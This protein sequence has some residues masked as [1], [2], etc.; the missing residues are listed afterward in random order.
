MSFFS[1]FKEFAVKGNVVDLAVGVI[2]GAAFGKIVDSLVGDLIMP[3]V[4]M[5]VGG[6]VGA[7]LFLLVEDDNPTWALAIVFVPADSDTVCVWFCHVSQLEPGLDRLA[8]ATSTPFTYVLSVFV[9]PVPF[10]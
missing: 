10:A 8:W 2:I 9:L 3:L 1:E 4:G 7:K 5:V 6:I